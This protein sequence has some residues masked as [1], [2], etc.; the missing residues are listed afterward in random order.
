MA[1]DRNYTITSRDI[2]GGRGALIL[3]STVLARDRNCTTTSRD[4]GKTGALILGSIVL[5]R[6]RNSPIS[7]NI[8]IWGGCSQG[9][10]LVMC[11]LLSN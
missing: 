6:D 10:F 9:C 1:R 7:R 11:R 8:H 4:I 3:G 5:A 2:Y